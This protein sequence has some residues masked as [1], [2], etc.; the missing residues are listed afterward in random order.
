MEALGLADL[1][2]G[3]PEAS[4][5]DVDEIDVGEITGLAP[6]G[7]DGPVAENGPRRL[8]RRAGPGK[9][10]DPPAGPASPSR[11]SQPSIAQDRSAVRRAL[12]RGA[13]APRP[14][15]SLIRVSMGPRAG[16]LPVQGPGS[17]GS[18]PAAARR[19][20]GWASRL[21]VSR[22]TAPPARR[23]RTGPTAGRPAKAA[24]RTDVARGWVLTSTVGTGAAARHRPA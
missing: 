10:R 16:R 22:R 5:N 4:L 24:S 11:S 18:T 3:P 12:A 6:L 23:P 20:P 9:A 7:V 21:V 13:S 1:D 8:P 15:G 19:P 17:P 2:P 14:G